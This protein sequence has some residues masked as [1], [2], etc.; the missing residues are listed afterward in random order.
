MASY[1]SEN[2]RVDPTSD[3]RR[4]A[5]SR[6]WREWCFLR[7]V[8]YHFRIRALLMVLILAFGAWMFLLFEPEQVKSVPQAVYY[9]WSL[10]LGEPPEEFPRAP[11]IRLLFFLVPVLGLTVI[12][13]GIIDFALMMRDRSRYEE[14]WCR[15]MAMSMNKHIIVV[16]FGRLGFRT[17]RMLRALGQQVVVIERDPE[18]QFLDEVRRDGSP[19]F[20][21]DARR[22]AILEDANLKRAKSVVV[23]TNDDLANLEV[24]LDARRIKPDIPVVLRMFDQNMADKIGEGFDIHM[25]MSQAAMSAPAFAA[26][27]IEP[28]IVNSF[29]VDDYL[30]I[31]QK[32]RVRTGDFLEGRTVAE[33]ATQHPISIV[34][35]KAHGEDGRL[36]PTPDTKVAVGDELLIQGRYEVLHELRRQP[37]IQS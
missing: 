16:G 35:R 24:A 10:V 12:V 17:F 37:M 22:E 32:W 13:E 6:L 26:A 15:T 28:D 8:F 33:I 18:N 23:A 21:G 20:I 29:V 5:I 7:V 27:A 14:S 1:F 3:Q 2:L 11:V 19:F 34:E 4:F 30:V 36:F 9:T 25:A 31:L